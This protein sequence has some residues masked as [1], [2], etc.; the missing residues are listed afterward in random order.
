MELRRFGDAKEDLVA[1][2][3]LDPTSPLALA[4][5]GILELTEG[6][7]TTAQRHINRAAAMAEMLEQNGPEITV[8]RAL[9]AVA[10]GADGDRAKQLG[11]GRRLAESALQDPAR[12]P[13]T[14]VQAL[15]VLA[16]TAILER[17]WKLADQQIERARQLVP[18]SPDVLVTAG[19]MAHSAS[20]DD[21]ARRY[22]LEAQKIAPN[23]PAVVALAATMRTR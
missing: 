18:D 20:R 22:L 2:L 23:H 17:N 1:T 11:E 19:G 5:L 9:A 3:Q 4:R 12:D 16:G 8:A 15:I 21:V 6:W 13:R 10:A 14:T 7:L